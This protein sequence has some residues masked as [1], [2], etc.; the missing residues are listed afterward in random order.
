MK[1]GVSRFL[2]VLIMAFLLISGMVCSLY[3]DGPPDTLNVGLMPNIS[4]DEILNT[5]S[6]FI[7]HL[8]E[9]LGMN[10][11][12][13]SGKSYMVTINML[14]DRK[15]DVAMLGG[16]PLF[17]AKKEFNVKVFVRNIESSGDGTPSR[18]AYHSIIVTRT[19]SGINSLADVRGKRISFTDPKSSSG[20]LFPLVG[21]MKLNIGLN[22]FSDVTYVKNHANSLL[23]VFNKKV[24]VGALSEDI[25]MR[26]TG[27]NLGELKIIWK[28]EP[29]KHGSW[30]VRADFPMEKLDRIKN[31]FLNISKR[32]DAAE[33]F[34]NSYIKGFL[35]ATESDYDNVLEV[36]RLRETLE[37]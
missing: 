5:F 22:D 20:F 29:I 24:D 3:A 19:D 28:S 12:V 17:T 21:L 25:Y 15:V 14:R 13:V 10:V 9:E 27:V 30:V 6:R 23:A 11:N 26:G 35:P 1:R 37:Q 18:E 7:Q 2:L 32:K 34:K 8:E 33:I 16:F 36:I 4:E 31:A